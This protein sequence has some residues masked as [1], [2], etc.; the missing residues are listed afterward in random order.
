MLAKA[1]TVDHKTAGSLRLSTAD[2]ERIHPQIQKLSCFPETLGGGGGRQGDR[3]YILINN[4]DAITEVFHFLLPPFIH[5]LV[6]SFGEHCLRPT[7]ADPHA[8]GI[9]RVEVNCPHHWVVIDLLPQAQHCTGAEPIRPGPCLGGS[10][11]SPR[12]TKTEINRLETRQNA[13]STKD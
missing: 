12:R 8:P 7:C 6:C 3:E 11:G 2:S 5:A 4:S 1:H 9:R 13:D 10:C